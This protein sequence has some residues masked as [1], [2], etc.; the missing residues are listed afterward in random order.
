MFSKL[1][2]QIRAFEQLRGG[3]KNL[4][5]RRM[6]N[7]MLQ[8]EKI[9]RGVCNPDDPIENLGN[10]I[11]TWKYVDDVLC[12]WIR[13]HMKIEQYSASVMQIM[14]TIVAFWLQ[15]NITDEFRYEFTEYLVTYVDKLGYFD[16]TER[17]FETYVAAATED[18]FHEVLEAL[19]A[20][21]LSQR[22]ELRE[23]LTTFLGGM[24]RSS[25]TD[26][27]ESPNEATDAQMQR[28][29]QQRQDRR[30][31]QLKMRQK[32][33]R[34]TGLKERQHQDP[35][36]RAVIDAAE[37]LEEA[38][39]QLAAT[40]TK[41]ARH[42]QKTFQDVIDAAEK[43]EVAR[44]QLAAARTELA[45]REQIP[46]QTVNDA[47]TQLQKTQQQLAA[48]RTELARLRRQN[49][50]AGSGNNQ[51]KSTVSSRDV[52]GAAS[53]EGGTG[54]EDTPRVA[55]GAASGEGGTGGEDTPRDA[56]GAA[57]GEGG[58]GEDG[59]VPD[60]SSS[61][62]DEGDDDSADDKTGGV[63]SLFDKCGC[64]KCT[65]WFTSA[66]QGALKCAKV[67]GKFI[68]SCIPMMMKQVWSNKL[69]LVKTIFSF[70]RAHQLAHTSYENGVDIQNLPLSAI[71]NPFGRSDFFGSQT[72]TDEEAIAKCQN[73]GGT[74]CD[75]PDYIELMKLPSAK[76]V[77][78][79]STQL[80]IDKHDGNQFLFNYASN[81]VVKAV[82]GAVMLNGAAQGEA[83]SA[84]ASELSTLVPQAG[85]VLEVIQNWAPAQV[86]DYAIN[87][88]TSFSSNWLSG[89]KLNIVSM[90]A[91]ALV[92]A[93]VIN[94]GTQACA[95][96]ISYINSIVL[97]LNS[98]STPQLVQLNKE[99]LAEIIG[100]K[101]SHPGSNTQIT[102]TNL[103][104]ILIVADS[105][106]NDA[107]NTTALEEQIDNQSIAE[108]RN[109]SMSL[110]NAIQH[111]E[112]AS[113]MHT[114]FETLRPLQNPREL[115]AEHPARQQQMEW[116]LQQSLV[117]DNFPQLFETLSTIYP[118]I[119]ALFTNYNDVINR[120]IKANPDLAPKFFEN[121][122]QIVL[123][124]EY[125]QHAHKTLI[126][127]GVLHATRLAGYS[128]VF[129]TMLFTMM[130][131][132]N[133]GKI[134]RKIPFSMLSKLT[135]ICKK[136]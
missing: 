94:T 53:G 40:R 100:D 86:Q 79:I 59:G 66:A 89:T 115:S 103:R 84:I 23:K 25:R 31:A 45:K 80:V 132:A 9:I 75:N 135:S 117:P 6:H 69:V 98:D 21:N 41:L 122:E 26:V 56:S 111:A 93:I 39:Q 8:K 96:G 46:S 38:Q 91:E 101:L 14:F 129:L 130:I 33:R 34:L 19:T 58:G 48:A 20:R 13:T 71:L 113:A 95:W 52:S 29:R 65:K 2:D 7:V 127:T 55:S 37:K 104:N 87:W 118:N 10:I 76:Y 1:R 15:Q 97:S 119:T 43:L 131:W 62:D 63:A 42:K 3:E 60:T 35:H 116:S 106:D 70:Y 67:G 134:V 74:D 128:S 61:S 133:A 64:K 24:Q 99:S 88:G 18:R 102:N 124:E 16:R 11:F 110:H 77:G 120:H 4:D 49:T 107:V 92:D 5:A 90:G 57:S 82:V 136:Q 17:L 30:K 109:I 51:L 54:G 81:P 44:Q 36:A 47:T 83:G 28:Q 32:A 114:A 73:L 72:M 68:C 126:P 121:I 78:Q 112:F 12:K 85:G 105:I 50:Q 123:D 108:I 22:P 27:K 125:R